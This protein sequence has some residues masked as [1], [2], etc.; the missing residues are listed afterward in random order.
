MKLYT[1][2]YIQEK[3]DTY[4]D[5][6]YL[7]EAG[8][9]SGKTEK[10]KDLY[11]KK[12]LL[13][14]ARN[15]LGQAT[16]E[17]L[18]YIESTHIKEEELGLTYNAEELQQ[19]QNIFI[20]IASLKK[21]TWPPETDQHKPE[22]FVVDEALLVWLFMLDDKD[23]VPYQAYQEFLARIIHTPKVILM[24]ATFPYFI[25]KKL[26]DLAQY[27]KDK[28][29]QHIK[30]QHPFLERTEIQYVSSGAELDNE[31]AEVMDRRLKGKG[32]RFLLKDELATDPNHRYSPAYKEGQRYSKGVLVVSERGESVETVQ[33][34][35]QEH[36]PEANIISIWAGN[37]KEYDY[38]LEGLGDPARA[39][40]IDMIITSPSW[41]TG[42]N[43]RNFAELTVGDYGYIPKPIHTDEDILQ[44]MCRDRDSKR[45]VIWPRNV[46][47]TKN[48]KAFVGDLNQEVNLIK[49]FEFHGIKK[50]DFYERILGDN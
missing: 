21:F 42:I 22:Y 32:N 46:D 8:Q 44:A 27:R 29:Y 17:R 24:G 14:G 39:S 30:Y 25:R 47:P 13:V 9:G 1:D 23:I 11:D 31:I 16:V 48:K 41:G 20:N 26:K 36:Y 2:R 5:G 40:D 34:K 49:H 28:N 50:D 18:G 6:I 43:I 7:I 45:W 15:R 38:L 10:L 12:V 37:S 35:W 19:F 3:F 33:S 4:E